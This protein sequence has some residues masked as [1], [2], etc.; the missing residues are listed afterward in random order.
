MTLMLKDFYPEKVACLG[1]CTQAPVVQIDDVLRQV[2]TE[3]AE[4]IL[5]I[6]LSGKRVKPRILC[7]GEPE[8]VQGEIR[9][10]MG[11]CCIASGSQGVK[12]ALEEALEE[13]NITVDVKQVGCIGICNQV[14]VLEIHKEGESPAVYA[15]IKPEEVREVIKHHFKPENITGK[16]R[17]GIY[18]FFDTLVNEEI[19]RSLRYY[20]RRKRHSV[21]RIFIIPAQYSNEF[22]VYL[23]PR[24]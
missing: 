5:K 20:D 2:G 3:Q 6:F 12:T 9:I 1:C 11:S 22:R 23:K 16:V 17:T 4:G 21:F 18:N 24:I 15:K 8:K 13:S 10:G 14:P 19:P 7:I